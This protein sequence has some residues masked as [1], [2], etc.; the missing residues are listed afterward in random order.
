MHLPAQATG[1]VVVDAGALARTLSRV[2][3][4]IIERNP[5]LD[6]VALVGIHTRGVPLAYRLRRLID[7]RSGTELD[8]G[9]LDITFHRDD[10]H[11]RSGAAPR[12]PQPVVRDTKLD[13]ELEGRTV[14]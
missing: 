4:E 13:F 7:E 10:V 11:V 3:N 1:K 5:E 6:D 12:R 2:D 8:L 9:Q 14:I